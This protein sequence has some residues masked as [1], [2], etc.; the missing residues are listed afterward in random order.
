M[1][2]F[3]SLVLVVALIGLPALVVAQPVVQ[4][5]FFTTISHNLPMIRHGSVSWGVI[6]GDRDLDVF[7]SGETSTGLI[8]GIYV[9]NGF[10]TNGSARFTLVSSPISAVVYSFSSWVDF[11][12][13]GDLDLL[14]AGSSTMLHPYRPSTRLYRNNGTTFTEVGAGFPGLHSGSSS[15][16][17]IDRDGD[18]DLILTGALASDEM[19]TIIARNLGGGQF[20]IISD[21]LPAF[22]YGDSA[23]GDVDK[24]GDL[25]LVLSGSTADG[26]HT[27]LFLNNNGQFTPTNQELGAVAFSSVDLGDYDNDGD[28]DLLVGGGFISAN[29]LDGGALLWNNSGGTFSQTSQS[30]EGMLAG[31]VTWGDYDNDGDLDVLFQGAVTVLGKHLSRIYRNEGGNKFSNVTN[32]IGSLFSDVEWGDFDADGDLDLLSTGFTPYG[33]SST[34]I[35]VN[36]RQVRPLLPSAPLQLES[37]LTNGIVELRWLPNTTPSD[38]SNTYVS[39]NVRVGTA[40]GLADFVSPASDNRTGWRHIP[41]PGNASISSTFTLENLPDGVYYWSVQAINNALIASDFAAEGSFSISNSFSTDSET[42]PELPTVFALKGSFPNPFSSSTQI[43][44]SL[45]KTESVSLRVYSIL[46]REIDKISAGMLGAGTHRLEWR[47]VDSNDSKV[48]SGLYLYE[49]R[50]GQE[51]KTGSITLIR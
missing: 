17:D 15:W 7:I 36:Q 39:Y 48:G 10:A 23:L 26:F 33:Q 11:D 3:R 32:L 2:S 12:S 29:L 20:Q 43:E 6:D 35:Y 42:D 9:N 21:A 19:V 1:S 50:A 24:D 18:Q 40:P 14:V 5:F 47:G 31:D 51:I 46:G 41:Q 44:F 34:H 37:Q 4:P 38:A 13:D 27:R 49:L 28:L 45:P 22:G 25:D 8:S 16:G 30:F